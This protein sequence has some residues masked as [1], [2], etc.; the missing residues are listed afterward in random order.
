MPG[1]RRL[2]YALPAELGIS[3]DRV[4]RGKVALDGSALG[5][6][7]VRLC[8]SRVREN[9]GLYI[10]L[11]RLRVTVASAFNDAT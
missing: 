7:V 6:V 1:R 11:K 9:P 10:G 2:C 8:H 4:P 5:E 3:S